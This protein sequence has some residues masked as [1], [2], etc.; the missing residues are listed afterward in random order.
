MPVKQSKAAWAAFVLC[1][2]GL[3]VSIYMTYEHFTGN[4]TLACP[5]GATFNCQA[6]TT[7]EWAEFLGVPVAVAGLA[8]FVVMTLLCLPVEINKRTGVLRLIGVI[9]GIISVLYLVYVELFKVH[10][11]CLWC[12]AVHVITLFLLGA[13]IWMNEQLRFAATAPAARALR[14][15]AR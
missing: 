5:A 12:T 15:Q 9:V 4:K 6:V 8:Y 2:L 14:P 1:V 11:I 7:S 13:V 3:L 10:A